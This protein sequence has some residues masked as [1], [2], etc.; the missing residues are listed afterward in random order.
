[1]DIKVSEIHDKKLI[2]NYLPEDPYLHLNN[3]GDLDD[4]FRPESRWFAFK[5][6]ER[7]LSIILMYKDIRMPVLSGLNHIVELES[8]M[9]KIRPS[10]ILPEKFNAH[11][12]PYFSKILDREFYLESSGLHHNM[13]LRDFKQIEKMNFSGVSPLEMKDR[14]ELLDLYRI[15]SPHNWVNERMPDTGLYYGFRMNG[16]I[17]SLA[18]IHVYSEEYREAALGNI[19][20]H[21]GYRNQGSGAKVTACLCREISRHADHI[22][23]NVPTGN[24]TANSV[25]RQTTLRRQ[26]TVLRQTTVR[27]QTTV[28][29]PRLPDHRLDLPFPTK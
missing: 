16:R 9:D 19:S 15:S 2:E 26:T 14:D 21:P 23:L 10:P 18:G 24:F 28:A 7:V 13:A 1:M 17:V 29:G 27:R 11:L 5:S 6:E 3:L 20:T 8:G 25:G 12:S 4:F 22:G